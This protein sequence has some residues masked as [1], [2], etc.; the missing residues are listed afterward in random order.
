MNMTNKTKEITTEDKVLIA[1]KLMPKELVAAFALECSSRA[2]AYAAKSSNYDAALAA[3]YAATSYASALSAAYDAPLTTS[4][5]AAVAASYA[6]SYAADAAYYT[7]LA[8]SY[9]T[10]A[11][12]AA[13]E[14]RE[15]QLKSIAQ[16]NKGI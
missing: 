12:R 2:S 7:A 10:N 3:S 4:Y 14:E 9:A 15:L 16:L 13:L 6:A 1:L 11:D 8:A 5:Y